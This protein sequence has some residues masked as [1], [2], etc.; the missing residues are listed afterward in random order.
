VN[1]KIRIPD[2]HKNNALPQSFGKVRSSF[3]L[4]TLHL[5]SLHHSHTSILFL[6]SFFVLDIL[7]D[8][9]FLHSPINRLVAAFKSNGS[10]GDDG[11]NGSSGDD[12]DGCGGSDEYDY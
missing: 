11:S 6:S 12:D 7:F 10:S 9:C 8:C 3:L 5:A 2:Q 1:R 4:S